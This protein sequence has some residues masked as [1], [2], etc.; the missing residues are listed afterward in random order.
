MDLIFYQQEL[1]ELKNNNSR[2]IRIMTRLLKS[3][4]PLDERIL[5]S[6]KI[7]DIVTVDMHK[8]EGFVGVR[9]LWRKNYN[10]ASLM[11]LTVTRSALL[12]AL[13]EQQKS[14]I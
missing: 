6:T 12:G 14:Q 2:L 4:L 13:I 1:H 3:N 8:L 7:R 11:S 9:S 5:L 10:K